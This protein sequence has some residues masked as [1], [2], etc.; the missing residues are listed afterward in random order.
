MASKAP[1]SAGGFLQGK[2]LI[3][4]PGMPDPRFERT[5]ILMCAHTGEG[6]MGLIVNKPVEG[7]PIG[8]LMDKL[9][10]KVT[11]NRLDTPVLF[12]GPV[13]TEQGL[14][15][16]SSE[17]AGTNS[18]PVTSDVSL[19]GTVDVLHA[20]AAGRG[21]RKALFA[22]GHSGWGAGQIEDELRGNG[23]VHC[24]FDSAILFDMPQDAK[25]SAALSKLGINIS[26][27]SAHTGNA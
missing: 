15:L 25:W 1:A 18:M 23:W 27:L 9:N 22:L 26:G 13:E 8:Q 21:P 20:I 2:F 10:I 24:D 17:F 7:I 16:H 11:A 5:V 4:L 3:A 12:G 6:A 19:T 14:I